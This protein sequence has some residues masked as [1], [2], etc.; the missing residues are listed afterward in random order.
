MEQGNVIGSTANR[1]ESYAQAERRLLAAVGL[2]ATTRN[3]RLGATGEAHLIEVGDGPPL[4]FVQG[5]GAPGAG[6]A[7]LLAQLDGYRRVAVDRPGFGLTPAVPH[8]RPTLRGLAVRFLGEV[9]DALELETAVLVANSMGSWWTTRFAQAHPD[10]VDALVHVGCP[11]LLLDTSAPL[12]MRLLG[13]RGLG[14]L[15]VAVQRPSA[16]AARFQLRMSGE[17]IGHASSD[18]ALID[19]L[20][21]MQHLPGHDATWHDLLHAVI[22]PRGARPGMAITA[23]ELQ[24]LD[25]PTLFVWGQKDTFGSPEVGRRA[26]GL[27][28][29]AD[30]VTIRQGHIPWVTDAATV[31]APILQWL[32]D[33]DLH[34][35][36]KTGHQA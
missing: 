32:A 28:P 1:R 10:R 36:L 14:R 3:V 2:D 31:A 12:P 20:V 27:L 7:A 4:V 21:A 11:A 6:W 25:V 23:E 8:T 26:A 17:T 24:Q 35:G 18:Q 13:V 16:R 34:R 15:L 33:R 29:R 5:G 9:L 30:L 19:V 22:G